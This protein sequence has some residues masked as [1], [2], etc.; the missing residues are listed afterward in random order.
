MKAQNETSIRQLEEE[1]RR[2]VGGRRRNLLL[3]GLLL[4]LL[5]HL[6]L[7]VYLHLVRR[8][9]PAGPAG[10]AAS[11][12]FAVMSAQELTPLGDMR[13]EELAPDLTA[14]SQG[15]ASDEGV[16]LEP[17]VSSSGLAAS[18]AGAVPTLGG[19]GTGSGSGSGGAST[20]GGGGGGG[21]TSYFGISSR[22]T[23]FAYIVDVSGSMGQNR[24]IEVAMREMAR[25]IEALPDYAWFYVVLFSS[26]IMMP[27]MLE[28][29]TRARPATISGLIRW[30]ND[31][32]PG[33]GTQPAPA[34]VQVFSL[35]RR[36][37]AIF[38]LTDGQ[39]PPDV[40]SIVAA[41]NGKGRRV[42]IT[43]IAFGDPSG[44]DQLKDIAR[45][46]GGVFRFVPAQ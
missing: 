5:A 26:E 28:G 34:F 1:R 33:G 25:S 21:G 17:D 9:L 2:E 39:I 20:L 14:E 15:Q 16:Q 38:F 40:S 6:G 37:D 45:E 8:G 3:L 18:G 27:R 19:S 36:P 42:V 30:L 41:L 44:Q 31:V 13:L 22:G 7:M 4:S 23:R 10:N 35:D 29:W 46:S 24:K 32:D 11:I 12:E 43:T